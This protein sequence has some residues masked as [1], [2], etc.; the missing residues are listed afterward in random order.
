MAV[1]SAGADNRRGFNVLKGALR[2]SSLMGVL[3]LLHFQQAMIMLTGNVE[4]YS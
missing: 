2:T 3:D 1:A 4:V